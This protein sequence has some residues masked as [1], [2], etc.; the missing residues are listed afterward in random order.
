[1]TWVGV[2]GRIAAQRTE[3]LDEPGPVCRVAGNPAT[4]ARVAIAEEVAKH[5][6]INR[7]RCI[8]QAERSRDWN[9]MIS[10]TP[11]PKGRRNFLGGAWSDAYFF[12]RD[13]FRALPLLLDRRGCAAES[14]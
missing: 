11:Y 12:T 9:S 5:V 13:N 2:F 4:P 14:N 3:L 8:R 1:M 6:R 7:Q 10:L